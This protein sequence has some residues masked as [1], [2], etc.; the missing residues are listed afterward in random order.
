MLDYAICEIAGKQYKVIPD[1]ALEVDFL[2]EGNKD[3]EAV[4]LLLSEGDKLKI[5]SPYL[6]EKLT[7][8]RVENVKGD[9]IRVS[10]F[11]AKANYRRTTGHRAKLTKVL[12]GGKNGT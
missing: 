9:K 1:K 4:V 7:L 8:K 2:G 6:K 10:K 5:G 12:L 3:I 11:H